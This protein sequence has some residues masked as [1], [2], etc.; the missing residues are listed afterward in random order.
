[1]IGEGEHLKRENSF[2]FG[3]GFAPSLKRSNSPP[4]PNHHQNLDQRHSEENGE[5]SANFSQDSAVKSLWFFGKIS[6]LGH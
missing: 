5:K 3:F 6:V 1:V 2:T 4:R